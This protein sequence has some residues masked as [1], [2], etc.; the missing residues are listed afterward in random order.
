M[1]DRVLACC[2]YCNCYIAVRLSWFVAKYFFGTDCLI[3]H[4]LVI[5]SIK[6]IEVCVHTKYILNLGELGLPLLD[7]CFKGET[8]NC[9]DFKLIPLIKGCCVIPT[10]GFRQYSA[11]TQP[12]LWYVNKWKACPVFIKTKLKPLL[13]GIYII[14]PPCLLTKL[15]KCTWPCLYS[16]Q[17][18][19]KNE[20]NSFGYSSTKQNPKNIHIHGS[21]DKHGRNWA[22]E[23]KEYSDSDWI[24]KLLQ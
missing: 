5:L 21:S 8:E 13:P 19:G 14:R 18:P 6:P 22:T 2:A 11:V 7:F 9:L 20:N 3:Y 12:C 23:L 16:I 10:T 1:C 17:I 15:G 24:T 4:C